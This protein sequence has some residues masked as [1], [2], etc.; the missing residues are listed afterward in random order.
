[1]IKRVAAGTVGVS[2][3]LFLAT[4]G[5][6]DG[7]NASGFVVPVTGAHISQGF[8]CTTVTLEPADQ[9]CPGGH[10]HSGVDL[11]VAAGTPVHAS[12]AG[13]VRAFQTTTGY[14]LYIV[15]DRGDGAS[16]LYGHL[17]TE[18]VSD[19]EVVSAGQVIGEVGSTGNS[20][21]PHLHFEIRRQGLPVDPALELQL[22]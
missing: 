21:G 22:P 16:S 20:T 13:R 9:H 12:T 19:G 11:A 14:G 3:V 8:G 10:W 2:V 6:A 7:S 5:L 4:A 18:L 1:M 17:E 15:V